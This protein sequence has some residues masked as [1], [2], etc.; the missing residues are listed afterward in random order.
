MAPAVEVVEELQTRF[1]AE[2]I[3]PQTTLDAVP[4]VW[5]PAELVKQVLQH[6]KS[7][8]PRPYRVLYDLAAIDERARRARPADQPAS[9]FT[10]Y[11]YLMS[12]ERNADVRLKVPLRGEWP[13]LTT[14]TDLWPAANWYEREVWDMYGIAFEGHPFLQRIRL[15]EWWEGHPL[16]KEHPARATEMGRYQLPEW[17]EQEE[18]AELQFHPERYGLS[19]SGDHSDYMFLNFGPHHTGTH[20]VL[21]LILRLHGEEILDVVP[22]IGYHHRGVEKMAERQT[23]H[24]F[25][26]YTDRVDYLSGVQNE[27]PYV[28]AI[29]RLAGIEVP[30]RAQIIRVMLCELWRVMN[31]LIWLGTYGNDVGAMSPVFLTFIDR[32]RGY[33]I[34][35]AICGF[36]MHPGWFRIGGVAQDL[37]EGWKPMLEEFVRVVRPHLDEYERMLVRTAIFRGRTEG[38]GSYTQEEA[39]DWGVTGPN[40]RATGVNWDLRK[41]RPY[42]SY[43]LFEFDVPTAEQGDCFAR[44]VVRMEEMRQSLRLIKQAIDNLP[45]GEY[46]S[47]SPRALPPRKEGAMEAIETLIHHFLAVSW[48]HPMPV[49]E[50]LCMTETPKGNT[51]YYA[52]SD[53]GTQAYRLRVRTPSFPHLQTLPLLARGCMLSDLV[54]ILGSIDFVLGDV[55]L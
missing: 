28:L 6:L 20:G 54:T 5:V 4:T 13:S 31:H 15:P 24:T 25:L 16:R 30:P 14:V 40:L 35:E 7:G 26:P 23:Y 10:A 42:S 51:G 12:Y 8:L 9:D 17:K 39:I 19:R 38:V 3:T 33:D 22:D 34:I 50:S 55:D 11:Y 53:T 27:L 41:A 32:E 49:G 29:E 47:D 18:E 46:K 2:H 44:A 36:R 43:D 48:G 45:Q 52:V 37:P 21:R 1:G